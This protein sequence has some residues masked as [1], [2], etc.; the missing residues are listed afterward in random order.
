VYPEAG[1]AS[2]TMPVPRLGWRLAAAVLPALLG[3]F[4]LLNGPADFAE[5]ATF[6]QRIASATQIVYGGA[7]AAVVAGLIVAAAWTR[8]A[9]WAW[10]AALVA[11][12]ALAP[13]VWGGTGPGP[14]LAGGFVA[15]FMAAFELYLLA[16]A[17]PSPST[18]TTS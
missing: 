7:G 18:P 5:S 9:F 14:A 6:P 12:G 8:P 3:G 17:A 11:T 16:R 1:E 13:V 2:R 4:G 10:A 15:A